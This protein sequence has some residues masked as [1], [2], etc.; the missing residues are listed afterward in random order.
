MVVPGQ[1]ALADPSAVRQI[2]RDGIDIL[3]GGWESNSA[4][5]LF[6][7]SN[8]VATSEQTL[9]TITGMSVSIYVPQEQVNSF[10]LAWISIHHQTLVHALFINKIP[11]NYKFKSGSVYEINGT[12]MTPAEVITRLK[13]LQARLSQQGFI[14]AAASTID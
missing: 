11:S 7:P 10:D 5:H 4:L 3:N 12:G 2:A 13:V 1:L 8:A 9:N 6:M 14:Q